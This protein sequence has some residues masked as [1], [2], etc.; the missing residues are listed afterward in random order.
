LLSS[1]YGVFPFFPE[2]LAINHAIERV[3]AKI[4]MDCGNSRM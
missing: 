2:A 1:A 4:R 3:V